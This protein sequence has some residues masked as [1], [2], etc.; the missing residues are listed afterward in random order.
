MKTG[1]VRCIEET[2]AADLYPI[3]TEDCP[4]GC[5]VIAMVGMFAGFRVWFGL[6]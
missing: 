2:N 5:G 1:E 4:I 3:R 6:A